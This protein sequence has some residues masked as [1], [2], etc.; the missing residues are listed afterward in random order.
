MSFLT[1]AAL[2][3][4][5]LVAV[6]LLAHLLRRRP[7]DEEP[8]AATHLV[9]SSPAVAQR[10]TA[11]EDRALLGIR[12]LAVL[13]LAALGATPLVR[14]ARLSIARESGASV[15]IAIVLDDS[16]SM[17]VALDA[18]DR[19][20]PSR[21]DRA[22]RAADELLSGMQAGDVVALVLAGKPARV[23][24]A[25]T[26]NLDAVRGAV[27]RAIQ[28]DR[29][30]DLDGAV[31]LASDLLADLPHV[32]KRV[33]VLS[34]LARAGAGQEPLELQ[35]KAKLW[36]PLDELRG[37]RRDCAVVRAD[38][39][40]ARVTVRAACSPTPAGGEAP[41]TEPRKLEVRSGTEVLGS[42]PLGSPEGSVDLVVRLPDTLPGD[43]SRLLRAVLSGSDAIAVDDAAP[44]V[45]QGG[46]L[47][48]GV[49]SDTSATL[50]ATGGA[51]PVEQAFTALSLGAQLRPLSTVPDGREELDALGLLI[52]DDVPG[53]TPS[54]RRELASW[55]ERGGVLLI[56]LGP[57]AAAAPLGSSF[58]PIVPGIVR[59]SKQ[60][61][62]GLDLASDT[63]FGEVN[64]GLDALGAKGR[65]L[66][67]LEDGS[68]LEVASRWQDQLPFALGQR[69]GRG[70]VQVITLPLTSAQSDLVLRPGFLQLLGKLADTARALGGTSRTDTGSSWPLEGYRDV[71]VSWLGPDDAATVV[72][73]SAALGRQE[74][75]VVVDRLG[76]YELKLDGAVAMRVAAMV[77]DEVDLRPRDVVA[78]SSAE[79]LG[80]TEAPVDVSAYVALILLGL[81]LGELGLRF[82]SP[83]RRRGRA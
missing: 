25:A 28:T 17:R 50:V 46:E 41:A 53:L 61:P 4:A 21:Y 71:T 33:V 69:M 38:R 39:L 75:R 78:A 10:R 30:S 3:V 44:V 29:G 23:A 47:R 77:E 63:V 82:G 79:A 5:A 56:T 8:F 7:P 16:L 22:R 40:G 18:D 12:V 83:R 49:V 54:Q 26:S 32:D 55:V 34:D 60:A 67:D 62:A 15:A 58:A 81:T 80:G 14:C 70:V 64:V 76:L 31:K 66:L 45:T 43:D 2:A 27:E 68:P 36:V 6:P 19:G 52:V 73:L 24:L 35:S 48:V 37:A 13:A 51:P 1:W 42:V 11:L 65:A 9:P 59:W 20:G 72:P 57:S 74:R